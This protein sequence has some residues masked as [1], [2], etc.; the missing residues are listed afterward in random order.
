MIHLFRTTRQKYSGAFSSL[1]LINLTAL[2]AVFADSSSEITKAM[3]LKPNLEQ[4]KKTYELCA[5]CHSQNGWGKEDGSF[6]VIAGQHRSVLIKQLADIRAR[7]RENPTMYPFSGNDI[8]G[9]PQGI[10]DVAGY[11]ETLPVNPNPGK[12]DGKNLELGKTLYTEKCTACHGET[13]EGN[14]DAYYPRIQGQHY[15]YLLRQLQWIRDGR[16]KNANSAMLE[17]V[18][19]LDDKTLSAIADYVSRIKVEARTAKKS[20]IGENTDKQGQ[21]TK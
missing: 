11:I 14:A 20:P 19:D 21:E 16:R 18:K 7:N 5:T 1:L 15:A 9:G 3:K 10:E 4:G 6:P 12:G 2:N 17:A 8:L 13:G